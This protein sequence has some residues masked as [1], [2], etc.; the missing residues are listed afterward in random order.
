MPLALVRRL[1]KGTALTAAEHDGNLTVLENAIEAPLVR[2][3]VSKMDSGTVDV[4]TQSTYTSTGL[5]GILDTATAN[6]I[7]LGTADT[8]AVR[9][10]SG[11]TK[12]M[13]V[14]GSIDA[15]T[16]SGNNKTLGIKLALNG[17]AIDETECR[18][19]TGSG[20]EEAKLVTKWMIEMDDD[21]EIALFIANQSDNGDIS[22]QRG[23]L[24]AIEVR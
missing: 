5:T 20:T 13:E 4:V 9:N 6:D 21:D 7:A 17:V 16:L 14:Y 12:L 8:F 18:A 3:Q 22:F 15:R 2:G 10:V 24:V 11:E 23:R 19:F 1:V